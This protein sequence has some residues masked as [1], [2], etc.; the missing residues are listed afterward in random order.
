MKKEQALTELIQV[1]DNKEKAQAID[2]LK[3]SMIEERSTKQT[4]PKVVEHYVKSTI[5]EGLVSGVLR[6]Y[7]EDFSST[8]RSTYYRKVIQEAVKAISEEILVDTS[9]ASLSLAW[10][11]LEKSKNLVEFRKNLK[12]YISIMKSNFYTKDDLQELTDTIDEQ[13]K[14]IRQLTE[15]KRVY[16]EIFGVL[17]QGDED[18]MIYRKY[19]TLKQGSFS[20]TEIAKTLNVSRSKLLKVLNSFE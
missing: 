2:L 17:Q 8:A 12:M 13:D 6:D 3:S 9:E 11:S 10:I 16:E 7:P 5:K 4:C 1:W 15:Y 14:E 19:K 18:L 20:D